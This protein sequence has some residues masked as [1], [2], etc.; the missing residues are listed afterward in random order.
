MTTNLSALLSSS[1]KKRKAEPDVKPESVPT[2]CLI[3]IYCGQ[4][5]VQELYALDSA[6]LSKTEKEAIANSRLEDRMLKRSPWQSLAD[7][8]SAR[9]IRL[10]YNL[11]HE[12]TR[13]PESKAAVKSCFDCS[14]KTERRKEPLRP[15]RINK[16]GELSTESFK[17]IAFAS[18]CLE[19]EWVDD[20]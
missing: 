3:S 5:E 2:L 14:W 8:S 6:Q 16:A 9:D 20:V 15:L 11:G 18:I 13:R 19:A 4:C 17:V 7:E 12:C 1:T 10:A